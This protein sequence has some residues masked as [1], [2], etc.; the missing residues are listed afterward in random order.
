MGSPKRAFAMRVKVVL[1]LGF[2]PVLRVR[3]KLGLMCFQRAKSANPV[4]PCRAYYSINGVARPSLSKEVCGV[5]EDRELCVQGLRGGDVGGGADLSDLLPEFP[6]RVETQVLQRR[7]RG[8][9]LP[10]GI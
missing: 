2:E 1:T 6:V 7:F 8:I 3:F 5:R 10:L 4:I 9:G